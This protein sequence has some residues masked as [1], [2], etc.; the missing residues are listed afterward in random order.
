MTNPADL[1]D[2]LLYLSA[3]HPCGYFPD[4]LATTLIVDPQAD[5]SSA[6]YSQL[7]EQGFRRSGNSVYRP[8]CLHCQACIPCRLDVHAFAPTRG[9]RR[10]WNKN[11]DLVARST[12]QPDLA[13][14]HALF[15]RYIQARHAGGAMDAPE[16]NPALEFLTSRWSDT[17][18]HE[19]RLDDTLI[20]AAVTDRLE[21]GL[22]AVYTYFAPEQQ[23]RSL[24]VYAILREIHLA[25]ERQLTWL[26]LGYWIRDCAKMSYKSQYQPLQILQHNHWQDFAHFP[27]AK[28]ASGAVDNPSER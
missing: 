27:F 10:I 16:E 9:Q 21:D 19:W 24:G 28:E 13:E 8:H 12:Y 15:Q 23:A 25:A 7:S 6:L 1:D 18:F 5:M 17:E 3:P 22:S 26:Y 2:L 14:H 4:R 20:A 11:R